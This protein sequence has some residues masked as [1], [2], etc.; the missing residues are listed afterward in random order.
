[1]K[2]LLIT[3]VVL[4]IALAINT[5]GL[6]RSLA[7]LTAFLGLICFVVSVKYNKRRSS[8]TQEAKEL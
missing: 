3:A 8:I 6:I 1:M 4:L 5:E 2:A 7:E